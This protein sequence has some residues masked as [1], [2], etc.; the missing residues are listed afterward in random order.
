MF[1]DEIVSNELVATIGCMKDKVRFETFGIALHKLQI[2]LIV[3][4]TDM[5]SLLFMY[6]IFGRLKP[7]IEEYL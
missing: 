3:V 5:A 4:V 2:G 7:I 1:N 6:F